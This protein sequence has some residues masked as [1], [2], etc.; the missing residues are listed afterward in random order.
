MQNHALIFFGSP[1]CGKD[2]NSIV[3]TPLGYQVVNMGPLL[4]SSAPP[5]I[6]GR[7][8]KG[9]LVPDDLVHDLVITNTPEPHTDLRVLYNGVPRSLIQSQRLVQML[10]NLYQMPVT[11][12]FFAVDKEVAFERLLGRGREDDRREVAINRLRLYERYAHEVITHLRKTTRVIEINAN[13]DLA[14]VQASVKEALEEELS[15]LSLP[16]T[17]TPWWVHTYEGGLQPA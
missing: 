13:Q 2:E 3:A 8:M 10:T 11:T 9:D 16:T 5:E 6:L 1:G 7:I 14:M 17:K 15:R 12:I 4:K